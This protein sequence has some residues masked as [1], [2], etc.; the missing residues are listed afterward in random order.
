MPKHRKWKAIEP[1][2]YDM[3]RIKCFQQNLLKFADEI[4]NPQGKATIMK[5]YQ[6]SL[7]LKPFMTDRQSNIMWLRKRGIEYD[8][9]K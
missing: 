4:T 2:M 7:K 6:E 5:F 3:E 9:D 8:D 1:S